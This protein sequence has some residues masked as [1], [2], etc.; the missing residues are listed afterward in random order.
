VKSIFSFS[1]AIR[2]RTR[3]QYQRMANYDA[4]Q[5]GHYLIFDLKH[6]HL[7]FLRLGITVSKR[8]GKAYKRN[9]FK[10]IVREAFR[11]TRHNLKVGL[12]INV[13]PRSAAIH[14]TSSDLKEE[15]LYYL[16]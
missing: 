9:R 11:L 7:E 16:K 1:K 8:F 4:R 5:V 3:R 13:K 10:R 15:F 14:A 2:L 12:D 6:N